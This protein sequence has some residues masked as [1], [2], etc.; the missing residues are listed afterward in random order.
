MPYFLIDDAPAAIRV[1]DPSDRGHLAALFERLSA[2]SRY[3]RYLAPVHSLPE[4]NLRRLASIDHERHEAVGAFEAGALVGV[5]HYFRDA[6]RPTQA[7]IAV[8][9]A[10]GHQQRGIGSSLL[11]ELA[12]LAQERGIRQFVATALQENRAVLQLLHRGDWPAD[13]CPEGSELNIV[14][15]L[16]PAYQSRRSSP[17]PTRWCQAA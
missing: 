5:A 12:R 2:R 14:L 8:E 4:R 13:V 11:R 3:L 10:D 16:T 1:L 9:V 6:D 15:N 17:T 7:E